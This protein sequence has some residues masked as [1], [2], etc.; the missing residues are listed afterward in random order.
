VIPIA[1]E[2]RLRRQG[3]LAGRSFVPTAAGVGRR[4]VVMKAHVLSR[5][6][7]EPTADIYFDVSDANFTI[8]AP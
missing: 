5:S 6:A 1:V 7:A 8:T 2:T 3:G 4:G